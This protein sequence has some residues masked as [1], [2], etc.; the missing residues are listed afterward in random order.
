MARIS[1]EPRWAKL[2]D[3]E[4]TL[5]QAVEEIVRRKAPELLPT[6]AE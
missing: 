2:I 6:D 5:P 4:T 1:I 3:F